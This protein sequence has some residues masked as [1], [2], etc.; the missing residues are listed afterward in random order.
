MNTVPHALGRTNPRVARLRRVGR[1]QDPGLTVI[2][3]FD[4]VR[5]LASAGEPLQQVFATAEHWPALLE[6]PAIADLHAANG[7]FELDSRTASRVAPSQHGQ[8]VLAVAAVPCHRFRVT[9]I[10]LYLDRIQDPGNLGAIVRTAAA[11]EVGQVLCSPGCADPFSPR[12]IRASAGHSL[13]LPVIHPIP[14]EDVAVAYL[15]ASG[16]VAGTTGAGGAPLEKW[17]PGFPLAVALGSEGQGLAGEILAAC[18]DVITIPIAS[19]VESL[20]VAVSAGVI[21][22]SL[23]LHSGCRDH[24]LSV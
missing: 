4:L 1:R 11:F 7:L 3:G 16:R 14:F 15:Q 23:R 13:R 10:A 2:D 18:T 20:N 8:G 6:I 22:A 9:S 19:S 5:E 24:V 17:Q 21:L 12:A